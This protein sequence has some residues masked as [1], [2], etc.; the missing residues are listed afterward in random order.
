MTVGT[1]HWAIQVPASSA[2]LGAG[3]DVPRGPG[4]Y[5][6]DAFTDNGKG[7]MI[8]WGLHRNSTNGIEFIERFDLKESGVLIDKK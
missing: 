5:R 4:A 8:E 6:P 2:N 3:F 1:D 7:Q